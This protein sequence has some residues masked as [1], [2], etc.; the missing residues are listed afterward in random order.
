[1]NTYDFQYMLAEIQ[2]YSIVAGVKDNEKRAQVQ[3]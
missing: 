2:N 1:M 3:E